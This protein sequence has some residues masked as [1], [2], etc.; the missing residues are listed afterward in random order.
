[1]RHW[2]HFWIYYSTNIT[3]WTFNTVAVVFATNLSGSVSI[4]STTILH[5]QLC[6]A[7]SL[8]CILGQYINSQH[9]KSK[10]EFQITYFFFLLLVCTASAFIYAAHGIV[11]QNSQKSMLACIQQNPTG[12]SRTSRYFICLDVLK[13]LICRNWGCVKNFLAS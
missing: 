5:F 8:H 4:P 12:C 11:G 9:S 1:M 10:A 7:P 13:P 2:C 3:Y 6:I